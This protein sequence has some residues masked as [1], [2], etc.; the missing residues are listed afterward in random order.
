M[1]AIN[2]DVPQAYMKKFILLLTLSV[3]FAFGSFAQSSKMGDFNLGIYGA[4]PLYNMNALLNVGI[5]GSL[6]YE[7]H[8]RKDL[9][10]TAEGGYE[11]FGVK[12]KLQNAYVPA[13]VAYVPLKVGVK[14]YLISGFYAEGQLGQ[15]I[16]CQ[17]GGGGAFDYSGGIGYSFKP[18]FEIGIRYEGWHQE[19]ENHIKDDY[20]I[21]GPFKDPAD[22]GQFALRL[23]ERF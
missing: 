18:G 10:F 12:T 22:F 2:L 15:S 4:L 20:G 14:Y 1:F 5:G 9:Y 17:H 23:A 8:F 16:F 7:Y 11:S 3:G 19:P 6:K 21:T 13:S